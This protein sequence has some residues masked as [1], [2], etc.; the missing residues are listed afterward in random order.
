MKDGKLFCQL[1]IPICSCKDSWHTPNFGDF[2][3]PNS[4]ESLGVILEY[5][6]MGYRKMQCDEELG[7]ILWTDLPDPGK[8]VVN[9]RL[10]VIIDGQKNLC[11]ILERSSY[12]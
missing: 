12:R 5:E 2:H 3:Q 9:S 6:L 10:S 11:G 7:I 1:E 8:R 4:A